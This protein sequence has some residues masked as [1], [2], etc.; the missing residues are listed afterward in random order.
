MKRNVL[1]T[2]ANLHQQWFIANYLYQLA[3]E[4]GEAS[5]VAILSSTSTFFTLILA[6]LYPSSNGDRFTLSKLVAVLA[7]IA[8]VVR[9]K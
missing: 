6:A 8:G 3:L 2:N 9:T 7:C 5:M 1:K 4:S